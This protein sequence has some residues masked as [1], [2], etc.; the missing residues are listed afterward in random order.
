MDSDL[1]KV[2]IDNI[3]Y[4]HFKTPKKAWKKAIKIMSKILKKERKNHDESA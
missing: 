1:Y 2:V 3:C 4:G